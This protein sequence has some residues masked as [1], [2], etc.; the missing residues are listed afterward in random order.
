MLAKISRLKKYI[1]Y[2]LSIVFSRGLEY[3]VLLFA[4]FT[5]GKSDYGDF[6]F[7]KKVIE[8]G[9]VAMAFGL[10]TILL[11]VTK[12]TN[13]KNSFTIL[14]ILFIGVLAVVSYPVLYYYNLQY[15]LIPFLFHAIFFNNGVLPVFFLISKGSNSAAQYKLIA[16]LI[17]YSAV[18][19]AVLFMEQPSY[20]FVKANYFVIPLFGLLLIKLLFNIKIAFRTIARFFS[21]FKKLL[22]SS[23]SLVVSNFVN[24][25]F[26]STDIFIIKAFSS[27]ASVDIADYSFAL[28]IANALI[29]VPF[30]IV[31]VDIEQI[32][33]GRFLFETR[34]KI[35]KFLFIFSIFLVSAYFL[36]T[37]FMY[38]DYV[39]N[40]DLFLALIFAK[41][42]QSRGVLYGSYIII[43]KKFKSNLYINCFALLTNL[44]LSYYLLSFM[45]IM[46][47][48]I[49][50]GISLSLRTFA[51]S[52]AAK[53][54]GF[55]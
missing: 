49:S 11:S 33:K 10:P 46:G 28:N 52:R 31:Q 14:S 50:S 19:F 25:M 15:F 8:L 36:L 30:T 55:K 1:I 37:K 34:Q 13:A 29:L 54:S 42:C 53:Q 18:I 2:G 23:L 9:A 47:V 21:I 39:G 24:I 43:K 12:H 26:L 27:T 20:A 40:L 35:Q 22:L 45:G 32:K 7:Y 16:S 5:L 48:A 6:E 51:L 3:L 41:W 38:T 17:F 4:A 44:L